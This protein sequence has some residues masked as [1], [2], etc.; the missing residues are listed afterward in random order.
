MLPI[1]DTNPTRSTP[2]VNYGL[3]SLNLLV[4]AVQVLFG[5][6]GEPALFSNHGLV[7]AR[8]ARQP[9]EHLATLVTST[10]LHGGIAH[11]AGNLLFLHIFGDNVEDALGHARYAFVYAACG[12]LA[13]LAEVALGPARLVPVVG[14]S[15]AIA[16]V[17]GGYVLLFP[18]APIKLLN[19]PLFWLFTGLF[20]ELPAWLVALPW[21]S[22]NVIS[23]FRTSGQAGVAFFAHVGG[24]LAGALL[25][26]ALRR[27]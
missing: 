12:A 7:P 1:G 18:R 20:I 10:F 14:A 4:F 2:F 13:G 22:W 9:L 15:G 3:L 25:S 16:G 5:S 8:F 6:L 26:A 17:L 27:R 11:L 21:F 23:A 24:F 19:F